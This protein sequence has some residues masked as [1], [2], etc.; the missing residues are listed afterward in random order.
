MAAGHRLSGSFADEFAGGE[1]VLGVTC[2]ELGGD[3]EAVNLV[4]DLVGA[5]GQFVEVERLDGSPWLL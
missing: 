2:G 3:G 5:G 1:F 4:G